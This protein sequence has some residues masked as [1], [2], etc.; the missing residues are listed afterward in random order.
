[1]ST[2]NHSSAEASRHPY[3]RRGF[4]LENRFWHENK[5]GIYSQ[6]TKDRLD[7]IVHTFDHPNRLM[8]DLIK[9]K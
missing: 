3:L 6:E 4:Y 9:T 2:N 8:L 1:M 5:E 7:S